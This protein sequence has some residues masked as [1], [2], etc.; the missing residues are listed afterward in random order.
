MILSDSSGV[1]DIHLIAA[2]LDNT[3]MRRDKTVSAYTAE[4]LQ[5]YRERGTPLAFA[6]ARSEMACQ[7]AAQQLQPEYIVSCGGALVRRGDAELARR[8]LQCNTA[9]EIITWCQ[10]RASLGRILAEMADGQY[11]V[12]NEVDPNAVGDYAHGT[13]YNFAQPLWGDVFKLVIQLDNEEDRKNA[14]QDFAQLEVHNYT[15]ATWVFFAAAGA[16]KWQ[17]ILDVACDMN[18]TSASIVAFGDDTG[19]V[20][21]LRNSGVGVAVANAVPEALAA[22]DAR[23]A[24]CDEDGVADWLNRQF[25]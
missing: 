8:V 16:T 20:E 11:F 6:T 17:G 10:K 3:L 7:R 12:S 24:D 18:I 23:C 22:A 25:R 15:G 9:N 4:V 14:L 5:N 1:Q 19:D 13:Q 21:M 2:D